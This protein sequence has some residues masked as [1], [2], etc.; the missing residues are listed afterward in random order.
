MS[1]VTGRGGFFRFR[2]TVLLTVLAAVSLWA[3]YDVRARRARN[4][5]QAPI[6]VGL[7][8]LQRG[9][10]DPGAVRSLVTRA[11]AL[12][13]RLGLELARYRPTLGRRFIEIEPF[14]PVPVS[15]A[16]P[17]EPGTTIWQ[18]LVHAYSL[19]RYTRSVDRSASVPTHELDSRIY[20]LAEP[21]RSENGLH[22]EGFS[23]NGG[24]VGVARVEL[25]RTTVDL[26]LFVAAHELFHTLGASDK[27]DADGRTRFP[28]GLADPDRVPLFPQPAAEIMARNRVVSA[29]EEV[30]P[31]DIDELRVGPLT[32]REIGWLN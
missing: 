7:V 27:Y 15:E 10:V 21:G 2:V 6:R 12:E 32:A 23:E 16:P 30:A 11:A 8:V 4:H 24:R 20:V 26:A 13:E 22:V 29:V 5:W 25:D 31:G 19:W 1:H 28:E 3:C 14:G 18:R 9:D 17:S